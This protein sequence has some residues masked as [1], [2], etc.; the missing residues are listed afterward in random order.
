MRRIL[1]L[2]IAL[3]LWLFPHP[4]LAQKQEAPIT[5]REI[6]ERLTRLEE[7]QK[8]LALRLEEVNT[9]LNK[10]IDEVNINLSKRIEDVNTNVNK[11]IDDL[12]AEMNRRFDD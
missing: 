2:T 8:T 6:V 5:N 12:R 7:G 9:G 4:A 11:R 10:R 1:G 3:A